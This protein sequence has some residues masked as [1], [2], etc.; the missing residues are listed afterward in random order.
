MITGFVAAMMLLIEYLNVVSS[1]KWS[2]RLVRGR[3]GQY[4]LA[5]LLGATPGC[6]GAFTVVAMY[7]HGAVSFG[8]VVAAMIATSGDEAF[9][10]FAL[11]PKTA[12]A[13]TALLFVLAL[14]AGA[15]VD[16]FA[17]KRPNAWPRCDALVLHREEQPLSFSAN[18]VLAQWRDCSAA[19]GILT[20][21]LALFA[22]AI[23][24]GQIGPPVWNWVRISLIV[25]SG[26][27]L[28]I[29]ATVPDH[30]L[31]EHLWRHVARK[32]V[33]RVFF[34]T[35]AALAASGPIEHLL[36]VS[37]GAA[38][39]RWLLLLMA[40]AIG[41]IPESGP[42]LI[43][44]TLYAQNAVPFGVL[45]ASSIV[46]DGHGMLPM[47]AHSR[48]AFLTVKGLNFV[49]GLVVGAAAMSLGC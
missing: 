29:V 27:S 46:Q 26:A 31:E 32:H 33:P 20:T 48:R 13:L 36:K 3:M 7:S 41:L 25:V 35:L 12:L 42:H 5:S 19:R 37:G 17:G 2:Q 16:F 45:L 39:N 11:I 18:R 30:F 49:F 47:L 38:Q 22:A 14:V 10:M 15:T 44:V 24:G 40:C 6:L 1:G 43:F 23:A 4:L 9:V 8:S 21:A 28:F 34:W